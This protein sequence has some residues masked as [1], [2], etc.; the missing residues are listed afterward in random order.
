MPKRRY[1]DLHVKLYGDHDPPELLAKMAKHLGFSLI[2]FSLDPTPLQRCNEI[3]G[4]VKKTCEQLGLDVAFRL[5]LQPLRSG[6]LKSLL[7]KY[8]RTF[9]VIAVKCRN[10]SVARVAARDRRVD[11]TYFDPS[12]VPSLL[13]E[14]QVN[15]MVESGHFIEVNLLDLVYE[16]PEKQARALW[17]YRVAIEAAVKKG[18][19]LIFSSGSSKALEM[20]APR[21]LSSVA[22]L[23]VGNER[24]ARDSVSINPMKLIEVNREK[25]KP[26][27]V[28]PGVKVVESW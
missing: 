6:E 25:L 3:M 16:Q 14:S 7:R 1:V 4:E 22:L 9:E 13:D 23:V 21:E 12:D 19:P 17:N 2:A 27:Y 18:V 24:L 8:R 20:R 28:Q 15:L 26:T 11:V 10:V 5:D